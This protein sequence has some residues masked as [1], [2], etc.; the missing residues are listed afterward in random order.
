MSRGA[1]ALWWAAV[2]AGAVGIGGFLGG[3]WWGAL[4][5]VLAGVALADFAWAKYPGRAPPALLVAAGLAGGVLA[6]LGALATRLAPGTRLALVATGFQLLVGAAGA[7]PRG[8]RVQVARQALV[9][10]G[11][12]TVVLS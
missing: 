10:L 1:D 12:A 8:S 11:H 9:A 2:V 4:A 6:T 5:M 3:A 7:R